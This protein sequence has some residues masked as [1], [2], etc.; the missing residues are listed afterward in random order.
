MNL[1]STK[2]AI[3]EEDYSYNSV[4]VG[5]GDKEN[6]DP[7]KERT[8][9]QVKKCMLSRRIEGESVSTPNLSPIAKKKVNILPLYET[10]CPENLP[11]SIT[12]SNEIYHK[13]YD[14]HE[15]LNRRMNTDQ[16]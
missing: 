4:Q 1:R 10:K 14:L 7:N 8:V 13:I 12:P 6:A 16:T 11:R 15:D 2:Q 5:A 3:Q 9:Y